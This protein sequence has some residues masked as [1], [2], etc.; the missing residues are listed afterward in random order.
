[1]ISEE[2]EKA[3]KERVE[4][5]VHKATVIYEKGHSPVIVS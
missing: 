2:R 4:N 3:R 5:R 1:M